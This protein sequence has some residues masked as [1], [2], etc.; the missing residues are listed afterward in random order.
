MQSFFISI[1]DF[2]NTRKALLYSLFFGTLGL[3]LFFAS[4]IKFV[5]DVYAIIPK[6]KKR[7]SLPRFL[8]TPNLQTNWRSW[9]H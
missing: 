1:Y 7:K 3:F 8:K 6:D 9:Y 5:E 4:R 2:F